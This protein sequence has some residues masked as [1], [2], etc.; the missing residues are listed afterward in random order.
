MLQAFS[1]SP[2]LIGSAH[3][4]LLHLCNI[5]FYN[6][7]HKER[8]PLI[9]ERHEYLCPHKCGIVVQIIFS[10]TV[11]YIFLVSFFHHKHQ[12]RLEIINSN[13]SF[14]KNSLWYSS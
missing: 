4:N 9:K 1:E 8:P 14:R 13:N 11:V 2:H 12:Q 10:E 6:V 3:T 7:L 5:S